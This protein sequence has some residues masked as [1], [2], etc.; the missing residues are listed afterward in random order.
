MAVAVAPVTAVAQDVK[1][2]DLEAAQTVTGAED[3]TLLTSS[4][5]QI[6]KADLGQFN[7]VFTSSANLGSTSG[8]GAAA[9]LNNFR[10]WF[11]ITYG[12][13]AVNI[14]SVQRSGSG[15]YTYTVSLGAVTETDYAESGVVEVK[16]NLGTNESAISNIKLTADNNYVKNT[17]LKDF[18]TEVQA[19]STFVRNPANGYTPLADENNA[20]LAL[21][22]DL[23][24]EGN[25]EKTFQNYEKYDI[26]NGAAGKDAD[27]NLLASAKIMATFKKLQAKIEGD[28]IN[29]ELDAEK[30]V[31]TDEEI[32]KMKEDLQAI[33]DDPDASQDL[34]DS[35]QEILDQI[36]GDGGLEDQQ[37]ALEDYLK[38]TENPAYSKEEANK[39]KD[40]LVAISDYIAWLLVANDVQAGI[41]QYKKLLGDLDETVGKTV[42][43]DEEEVTYGGGGA[44][45]G[46]YQINA[47]GTSMKRL[48]GQ[49]EA[50]KDFKKAAEDSYKLA[51]EGDAEHSI[52]PTGKFVAPTDIKPEKL[53]KDKDGKD[54]PY[55]PTDD[56]YKDDPA[57][58]GP[59]NKFD[60]IEALLGKEKKPSTAA[61]TRTDISV[62][63]NIAYVQGCADLYEAKTETLFEDVKKAHKDYDER[64]TLLEAKFQ[65]YK[66][67]AD[68][69]VDFTAKGEDSNMPNIREMI[70]NKVMKGTA[71]DA[72]ASPAVDR[73]PGILLITDEILA[74]KKAGDPISYETGKNGSGFGDA[75]PDFATPKTYVPW[76]MWE[77]ELLDVVTKGATSYAAK[78]ITGWTNNVTNAYTRYTELKAL[79]NGTEK[80]DQ[81]QYALNKLI[82]ADA[83]GGKDALDKDVKA[84]VEKIEG[85]ITKLNQVLDDVVNKIVDTDNDNDRDL[86][87]NFAINI[88]ADWGNAS[89]KWVDGNYGDNAGDEYH[90]YANIKAKIQS[91]TQ[92]A[93]KLAV[94]D[95]E[96]GL[97]GRLKKATETLNGKTP[98]KDADDKPTAYS[99]PEY[100]AQNFYGYTNID[101]PA[102]AA[103]EAKDNTGYAKKI[104]DWIAAARLKL[105]ADDTI[106]PTT[107]EINLGTA[108]TPDMWTYNQI[109]NL[110]KAL[111]GTSTNQNIHYP[112]VYSWGTMI[113]SA[114]DLQVERATGTSGA[115]Y[116]AIVHLKEIRDLIK[117]D[118][119]RIEEI[120]NQVKGHG[121]YS[122]DAAPANYKT[123]IDG[124]KAN[125]K[126]VQDE[127]D[128]YVPGNAA[129]TNR[130]ENHWADLMALTYAHQRSIDDYFDAKIAA[131]LAA[132][133]FADK[134][135]HAGDLYTILYG[136]NGYDENVD[137]KGTKDIDESA[138]PYAGFIDQVIAKYTAYKK[139]YTDLIGTENAGD[140]FG[141]P[142]H[143][144][145]RGNATTLAAIWN[146]I[147]GILKDIKL[148]TG[149]D[150][151][152][153]NDA[154]NNQTQA[155]TNYQNLHYREE[156]GTQ[157][158]TLAW[159][160]ASPSTRQPSEDEWQN[161]IDLLLKVRDMLN[162]FDGILDGKTLKEGELVNDIKA[163]EGTP[164]A[165]LDGMDKMTNDLELLKTLVD[166]LAKNKAAYDAII[167]MKGRLEKRV[168]SA[169]EEIEAYEASAEGADESNWDEKHKDSW[170]LKQLIEEAYKPVPA[171]ETPRIEKLYKECK[172]Y[173]EG[174]ASLRKPDVEVTVGE[175]TWTVEDPNQYE[176]HLL[177]DSLDN[178]NKLV[179]DFTESFGG[180]VT[181]NNNDAFAN[182]IITAYDNAMLVYNDAIEILNKFKTPTDPDLLAAFQTE[183][184]TATKEIYKA[185]NML[186][187]ANLIAIE[188]RDECIAG[189][190]VYKPDT[191]KY[192]TDGKTDVQRI[193]DIKNMVITYL[194]QFVENMNV[195]AQT[196]LTGAR[197]YADNTL[198]E[199]D[200]T[201]TTD[202]YK[203]NDGYTYSKAD[204]FKSELAILADAENYA[205]MIKNNGGTW[206]Y[207]STGLADGD[208]EQFL[209][210]DKVLT[211]VEQGIQSIPDKVKTKLNQ[212]AYEDLGNRI[213]DFT[214]ANVTPLGNKLK[215]PL[216]D[217]PVKISQA[218]FDALGLEG[219]PAD[220]GYGPKAADGNFWSY[221]FALGDDWANQQQKFNTLKVATVD[222]AS[223]LAKDYWEAEKLPTYFDDEKGMQ[224]SR[225]EVLDLLNLFKVDDPAIDDDYDCDD[226][227]K[228]VD[229]AYQKNVT[230]N[231]QYLADYAA[232]GERL[233][234][235]TAGI[236][237]LYVGPQFAD[238]LEDLK[239]DYE[240][241]GSDAN[242]PNLN[243]MLD[244]IIILA[245]NEEG[246]QLL[247]ELLKLKDDYNQMV[248]AAGDKVTAYELANGNPATYTAEQKAEYEQ[249]KK[250]RDDL[251]KKYTI[252]DEID[253]GKTLDQISDRDK[254]L[255]IDRNVTTLEGYNKKMEDDVAPFDGHENDDAKY[256]DYT[257]LEANISQIKEA[258]ALDRG[259]DPAAIAAMANGLIERLDAIIATKSK[260][261]TTQELF[262]PENPLEEGFMGAD[263][264]L[265]EY[266]LNADWTVYQYNMSLEIAKLDALRANINAHAADIML[267]FDMFDEALKE[268]E[269]TGIA[270]VDEM[271]N[272]FDQDEANISKYEDNLA[273]KAIAQTH[274]DARTALQEK[275]DVVKQQLA[276]AKTRVAGLGLKETVID[277]DGNE[278]EQDVLGDFE[279]AE[280]QLNLMQVRLY[281]YYLK[282]D[283]AKGDGD[284]DATV[285][286]DKNKKKAKYELF[287]YGENKAAV[288]DEWL[289]QFTSG[290]VTLAQFYNEDDGTVSLPA[291]DGLTAISDAIA[292]E[293]DLRAKQAASEKFAEAAEKFVE[294]FQTIADTEMRYQDKVDLMR[295]LFGEDVFELDESVQAEDEFGN[296]LFDDETGEPIWEFVDDCFQKQRHDLFLAI[297]D[298]TPE[299]IP[300]YRDDV[301]AFIASLE[302]LKG[303][304]K[305]TRAGDIAGGGA[306]GLQPDGYV[307]VIDLQRL[308]NLVNNP[309]EQDDL[310]QEQFKASDL[311]NDKFIDIVDLGIMV[312]IMMNSTD[313][314]YDDDPYTG[315]PIFAARGTM[316]TNEVL[317]ADVVATEGTTQRIAISLNNERDYTG[318]QMDI[319]L[320]QGMKLVGQSLSDR[321]N[322]Q[323]LYANE[324]NGK[325]RLV[326]FDMSKA[327]FNGNDGA[328]IYLDVETDETYKGGSVKYENIIFLTTNSRGVSFKMQGETTGIMSRM[329]DAA[330]ETIYNVGGR[331]M[332]GLKKGVNILRG[333]NGAA[334]KVI[335]K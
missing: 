26:F 147:D 19:Y 3:F 94:I 39:K 56:A 73:D 207:Q 76:Q 226:I 225:Q 127:I 30:N 298:Q 139:I 54:I 172:A 243:A 148:S 34:K 284:F 64:M 194:N 162:V 268:Y 270:Q 121:I 152:K 173:E 149:L 331:V 180:I 241:H 199:A 82:P 210:L 111:V 97:A 13:E 292:A 224:N 186:R 63:G 105:K 143:S 272:E 16:V 167:N 20:D 181:D 161:C 153:E 90:S 332:N 320:P 286:L 238:L 27:G 65:E 67:N 110:I 234:T 267:Y 93:G 114:W 51:S 52:E 86:D 72:T 79:V 55:V 17:L 258:I 129:Y 206:T 96:D 185:P 302:N 171:R 85:Y 188:N 190:K 219:T 242:L 288:T 198:A 244:D 46:T 109:D 43:F 123:L 259:A 136:S 177:K 142:A 112:A 99:N 303:Q 78:Y 9:T 11:T 145:D 183:F 281:T 25:E 211:D 36:T 213:K 195:A 327:A 274:S 87:D 250:D 175:S 193:N 60:N 81:L 212:A 273:Q 233:A 107:L 45:L 220:Y 69:P 47:F 169:I 22:Q 300:Q 106:N 35:S 24:L 14:A 128:K 134:I 307:N 59:G 168:K 251:V 179:A 66:D 157:R 174:P 237:S 304:A 228:D 257:D 245:K 216:A 201:I 313:Y 261:I 119:D 325:T 38:D 197:I 18:Y 31:L 15:P 310:T 236:L 252:D 215:E 248:S 333:E 84:E 321:A 5:V 2:H 37:K 140:V 101:N 41:D 214:A 262:N 306:D 187:D 137:D 196:T 91:L 4:T 23:A 83:D 218:E 296:L 178:L 299:S 295:T 191:E 294:V 135:K 247:D 75:T 182:Q 154:A 49:I 229:D 317:R 32:A 28:K 62:L 319:V 10:T 246:K 249:L 71:A 116:K 277:G 221:K 115:A 95:G 164:N 1:Y 217:Y 70:Y 156:H 291:C 335:K 266:Y 309:S 271:W 150:L 102:T 158:G 113:T 293:V 314:L 324:W 205:N 108:E 166:D 232:F 239:Q 53:K 209:K 44:G 253:A 265:N 170:K 312:D 200:N 141:T 138:A 58:W 235:E 8:G 12:G 6:K 176:Y 330:V 240:A 227:N 98:A 275:I 189:T 283:G 80:A 118:N 122:E 61:S 308:L 334:K 146:E 48:A 264:G 301:D 117:A 163:T 278:V 204:Y 287:L 131:D 7:I 42:T 74:A 144:A 290:D 89:S 165:T 323:E 202:G 256:K 318:F 120:Y 68:L 133:A 305:L 33:I 88:D 311:N 280:Y 276:D 103:D 40:Q 151:S 326:G 222:A 192:E 297:A 57:A 260:Y 315:E 289:A 329:A 322:G 132:G 130:D 203:F 160:F 223:K 125:I 263:F 159:Y 230:D 21:L 77:H 316:K 92:L 328:V 126:A 50:L 279:D 104:T 231:Q 100:Q 255:D 282:R 184:E 269:E 29:K 285:T 124:W 254:Q 155:F 208:F